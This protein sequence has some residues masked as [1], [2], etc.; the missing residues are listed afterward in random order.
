MSYTVILDNRG[1]P[2]RGQHPNLRLPGVPSRKAKVAGFEEASKACRDY[3]EKHELG[4]GNWTGGQVLD[5]K[6]KEVAYVSYGGKVW[7]PG[8]YAEG[9]QPLWPKEEPKPE[10][11]AALRPDPYAHE[12][13]TLDTPYG[14][15]MLHGDLENCAVRNHDSGEFVVGGESCLISAWLEFDGDRLSGSKSWLLLRNGWSGHDVDHSKV[16]PVIEKAVRDWMEEPSNMAVLVRNTIKTRHR[17]IANITNEIA[18]AERR[19][20]DA[21]TDV[22]RLESMLGNLESEAPKPC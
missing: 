16:R 21:T 7:P 18:R 19:L 3:I 9:V 1:N 17:A 10:P 6:G 4:G 15:V 13:P 2:D 12:V 22:E 5:A 8:G 11:V 14:P 20:A